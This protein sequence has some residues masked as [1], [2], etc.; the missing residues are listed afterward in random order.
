MRAHRISSDMHEA[1]EIIKRV[2][3]ALPDNP[4]SAD[5]AW[6]MFKLF[7]ARDCLNAAY[8]YEQDKEAELMEG[9]Y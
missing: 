6:Q 8:E 9:F 7:Q 5:E 4:E 2:I 3:D 1:L